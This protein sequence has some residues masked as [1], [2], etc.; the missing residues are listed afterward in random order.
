MSSCSSLSNDIW[1]KFHRNISGSTHQL[2]I[3]SMSKCFSICS[4]SSSLFSLMPR[5]QNRLRE[6]EHVRLSRRT[7][8]WD[9]NWDVSNEKSKV[10]WRREWTERKRER[11]N[12]EKKEQL[13]WC[14]RLQR[15]RAR[16]SKVNHSPRYVG[17]SPVL[18]IWLIVDAMWQTFLT[19]HVQHR[20]QRVIAK[21]CFW[22]APFLFI[23]FSIIVLCR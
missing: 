11:E 19:N 4:S 9:F 23:P 13:K 2:I 17:M 12:K 8:K 14:L 6:S 7:N 5:Y 15:H 3:R 1:T 16:E 20:Y 18:C 22:F 21:I 10:E